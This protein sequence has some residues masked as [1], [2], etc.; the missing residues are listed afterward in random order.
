MNN[1]MNYKYV[2]VGLGILLVAG[3]FYIFRG[4]DAIVGSVSVS[5]EYQSTSTAPT[6]STG[7][8]YISGTKTLRTTPGALGSVIVTGASGG[9]LLFY[10]ATTTNITLR[11]AAK[12][13]STLLLAEIPP[14]PAA[15]TYVF[16]VE[17]SD[18][19]TVVLLPSLAMPT[20]TITYR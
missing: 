1:S 8:T 3:L 18:G 7:A 12:A 11:D 13:T 10:D 19:L 16:D 15:G 2:S 20:T 4:E 17:F 14:S 6:T 5:N 9:G